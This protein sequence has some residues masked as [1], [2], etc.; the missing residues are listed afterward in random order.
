MIS[1]LRGDTAD[2]LMLPLNGCAPSNSAP[3]VA[4]GLPAVGF[5][6]A[7]EAAGV[8]PAAAAAHSGQPNCAQSEED[9]AENCAWH[10]T[11]GAQGASPPN[12]VR[13]CLR[14][15][16]GEARHHL[17]PHV[18]RCGVGRCVKFIGNA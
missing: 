4:P 10:A 15:R 6:L 18:G 11:R 1:R 9:F 5:A 12:S 7:L 2:P 8:V 17:I 13:H 3:P 14:H 16:P